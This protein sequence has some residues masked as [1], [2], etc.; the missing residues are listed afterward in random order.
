LT[1][2]DIR[3]ERG[4]NP[5]LARRSLLP[6]L[7]AAVVVVSTA[8]AATAADDPAGRLDRFGSPLPDRGDRAAK[9]DRDTAA[10]T[11]AANASGHFQPLET[12]TTGSWPEN[13][14]IGDVTG[15][16]RNDVLLSTTFYFDEENDYKLFVYAQRADGTLAPGVKYDTLLGYT[17][18]AGIAVL[19]A[20][21]DGRSDVAL[22]T[23]SGVQLFAQSAD[24]TLADQGV[25]AG[26][27][28]AGSVIATDVDSDGDTDLL[29]AGGSGVIALAQGPAGV[30][31]PAVVTAQPAGTVRA[32][33]LN[34]DGRVDAATYA[35]STATVH[36]NLAEGW[37][38]QAP[39]TA[40]EYINSIEVADVTGE[41]RAD[42]VVTAG[43]NR[44][45]SI[46]EV[47]GQTRRGTLDEGIVYPVV[48]IPEPVRAADITGDGRLDLVVAHGGWNTLSTLKQN[49]NRTLAAPVTDPLPYA[50]HYSNDGLAV[51]DVN[52]DGLPDVVVADYNHGLLIARNAHRARS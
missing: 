23:E 20:T 47:F 12:I 16:G 46:V 52:S 28:E 35:G 11:L 36:L 38:S 33:D 48:D 2:L 50:S 26:S 3:L 51:G 29:T 18:Q 1:F 45:S 19:D 24:G 5:L 31:T 25:L 15:D 42:L 13:V 6:A 30:F 22:T 39:V 14:A 49:A 7:I 27:P 10:R 37:R 41:G 21:G 9:V 44:P 8:T 43:G 17:G 32:G 40:A 34:G 4:R